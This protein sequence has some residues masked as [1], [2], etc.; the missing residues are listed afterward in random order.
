M[1]TYPKRV[2]VP[3]TYREFC[4]VPEDGKR[5]E[6]IEGEHIVTPAPN[7]WHQTVSRRLQFT[8]MQQLEL[9]G[10]AYVFNAPV[11]VILSDEDVFEPD[12]VVF[13]TSS[14][15]MITKRGIEGRPD[16]V[17]EIFSPST[18]SQDRYLKGTAYAHWKIP[19]YW[20]VDPDHGWVE[21]YRLEGNRYHLGE[22]YDR[23]STLASPEFPEIAVPLAP[24]FEP[25]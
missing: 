7:P 16:L 1:S 20:L 2:H 14:R 23:V 17:V 8:L 13:R 18:K 3:M 24:V 6:L 10:I 5:H 19:E 12:L 11:D 9:P 21:V 15:R 22:R 25:L 4:E